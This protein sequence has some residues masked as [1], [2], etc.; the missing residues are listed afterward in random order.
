MRPTPK[1]LDHDNFFCGRVA[2]NSEGDDGAG[3]ASDAAAPPEDDKRALIAAA[4]ERAKQ[5]KAEAAAKNVEHLSPAQAAQ[6]EE[7][8]RRRKSMLTA[9]ADTVAADAIDKSEAP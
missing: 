3:G 8:E 9:D 4:L 1:R 6:I 2:S 7:A 5:Q